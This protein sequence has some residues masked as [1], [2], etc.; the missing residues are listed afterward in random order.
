MKRISLVIILFFAVAALFALD[1]SVRPRGFAFFPVGDES[2]GRFTAGG[3]GDLLLDLDLATLFPSGVSGLGYGPVIEGGLAVAPLVGGASDPLQLYSAGL[4]ANVFYYPLSRLSLRLDGALGAYRGILPDAADAG[5]WWHT[6]GNVG[7]RITP[8]VMVSLDTGFRS[9]LGRGNAVLNQGIY[10]GLSARIVFET[11]N[12]NSGVELRINQREPVI[13]VFFPLYREGPAA[14]LR[15]TNNENME[16]R[17]VRASF[18]AGAYTASELNCG[19]LDFID[20][21]GSSDLSL[22]ADFSPAML[23]FTEDG[24]ISGEVVIRYNVLGQERVITR[25][26]SVQTYNRNTFP[27]REAT[28]IDTSVDW[29]GLAAFVS[30]SSTEILEYSKYLVGMARPGLR[31]GLS[32]PMQFGIW[33][34]EGLRADGISLESPTAKPTAA[35]YINAQFPAQT[36]AYRSGTVLDLALLYSTLLESVGIPA[37]IVPVKDDWLVALDLGIYADEAVTEALFD[38][39]DKLLMSGDKVWL[40][41]SMS[42]LAGGFSAAWAEGAKRVK[43]LLDGEEEG[44]EFVVLE[45]AWAFYPPA[46]LPALGVRISRP[47]ERAVSAG[48]T[49]A[50]GRYIA[51]EFE[52]RIRDLTRQIAGDPSGTLYNRLGNLY[53]RSNRLAEAKAAY[54]RA[55]A[56]GFVGAIINRGNLALTER[57]WSNAQR[58]YSQALALEPENEAAKWGLEQVQIRRTDW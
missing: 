45:N 30:P 26:V 13:P 27:A 37:G 8:S 23:N 25:G 9:Y 33:L 43:A 54:D 57:D 42:N 55:I 28:G 22:Y 56:M 40:P 47:D 5:F 50:I 41:L 29:A 51:D 35:A 4:G 16:I 14:S 18:R 49:A 20:R 24:R 2:T 15:I 1:F 7:F 12:R 21:G 38:G 32:E 31:I 58:L 10:L 46:P 34:L 6:G 3:G 36:L 44:G 11:G 48:A 19:T 53:L 39:Q 52:P 17:N